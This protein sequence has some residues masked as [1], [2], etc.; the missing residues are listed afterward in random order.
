MYN[1]SGV[2]KGKTMAKLGL[3]AVAGSTVDIEF[4]GL[5]STSSNHYVVKK[6]GSQIATDGNGNTVSWSHSDWSSYNFTVT[7][8]EKNT[9]GENN[10][11]GGSSGGGGGS[12]DYN[13]LNVEGNITGSH[14]WSLVNRTQFTANNINPKLELNEITVTTLQREDSLRIATGTQ[15]VKAPITDNIYRYYDI[16]TD[17]DGISSAEIVFKVNQSFA[18][19]YDEITLAR[20]N[21]GWNNL[22]T[23]K[24]REE[25]DKTVYRAKSNGLSYFA[26]KGVNQRQEAPADNQT[27]NNTDT[28]P[29]CG[30]QTCNRNETWQTCQQDCQKPQQAAKAETAV[31]KANQQVQKN[32]EGFQKLKQAQTQL[33]NGNYQQ[34]ETLANQALQMNQQPSEQD[35][36]RTIIGGGVALVLLLAISIFFGYRFYHKK[37]TEN[38]IEQL[39]KEIRSKAEAGRIDNRPAI[40]DKLNK[41]EELADQKEYTDA[42]TVIEE[43]EDMLDQ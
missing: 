31:N 23:T 3:E 28:E 17:T 15:R 13:P 40:L 26:V 20:Y 34:A 12:I 36:P 38:E 14:S 9:G 5:P 32:E 6:T 22:P 1:L 18:Q 11:D 4:T 8:E 43:A 25:D 29:V 37:R 19:Q 16:K 35:I 30:D 24:L 33:D 21:N 39:T 7:Y 2:S 10:N 41:A 27:E 42:E